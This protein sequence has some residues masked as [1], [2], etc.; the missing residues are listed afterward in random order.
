M[1]SGGAG[2]LR[3]AGIPFIEGYGLTETA[4]VL[5]LNP[6]DRPKPGTVGKPLP[7][8]EIVILDADP[9]GVGEIAAKGPN[10]MKGY[11][12]NPEATRRSSR[13]AGS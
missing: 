5:S 2:Q 10:I 3:P 6:L 13:T 9:E 12:N 4:P 1:R 11:F 8:V 7:N